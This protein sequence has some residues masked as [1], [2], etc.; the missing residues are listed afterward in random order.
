MTDEVITQAQQLL[1]GG[2][3]RREVANLLAVRYDTLRKAIHQGRLHEPPATAG[4]PPA[5]ASDKSQRS[6]S[7][8]TAE[9]RW[10]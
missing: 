4:I 6:V 10:H 8:A 3:S 5:A 7:D 1:S 9:K 2:C